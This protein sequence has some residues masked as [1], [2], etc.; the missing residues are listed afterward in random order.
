MENEY[1]AKLA[2]FISIPRKYMTHW[3]GS[4]AWFPRESNEA[5][6]PVELGGYVELATQGVVLD[7]KSVV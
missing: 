7:R 5:A 1:I 4:G 6:F 2:V 3:S